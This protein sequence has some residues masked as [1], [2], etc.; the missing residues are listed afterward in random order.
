MNGR[1]RHGSRAPAFAPWRRRFLGGTVLKT[2]LALL[3][4][5]AVSN[6]VVLNV[7]R[8]TLVVALTAPVLNLGI[9]WWAVYSRVGGGQ[10]VATLLLIVW[11]YLLSVALVWVGEVALERWRTTGRNTTD[12]TGRNR[13]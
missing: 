9:P 5:F 11:F 10:A 4:W 2:T 7:G 6:L 8:T 12:T 3:A 1:S 13:L